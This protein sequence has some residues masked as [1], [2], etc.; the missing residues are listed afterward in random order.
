M[1]VPVSLL[2]TKTH[3]WVML[4]DGKA[5]V[6]LTD[7]AQDALGDIVFFNLPAVGSV[8]GAGDIIGEVESVKAVSEICAAVG[9]S[10][11]AVN[12]ALADSPELVNEAPYANWIFEIEIETDAGAGTD[13]LLTPEQYESFCC[14][15]EKS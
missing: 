10:I 9:G 15:E 13:D 4:S 6:G 14:D 12:D 11:C 2:Y 8:V 7:F 3:E 5:R 1:E